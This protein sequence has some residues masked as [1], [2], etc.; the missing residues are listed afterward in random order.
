MFTHTICRITLETLISSS[1]SRMH[2]YMY[3]VRTNAKKNVRKYFASTF[4]DEILCGGLFGRIEQIWIASS[5]WLCVQV[6]TAILVLSLCSNKPSQ[7]ETKQALTFSKCKNWANQIKCFQRTR[8]KR[9][10]FHASFS[11]VFLRR[12]TE[13]VCDLRLTLGFLAYCPFRTSRMVAMSKISNSL[14]WST[15]HK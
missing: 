13:I 8:E 5:V 12:F 4:T 3:E 6:F 7:W 10:T 14:F 1:G 11:T 9:K 15:Q 2:A